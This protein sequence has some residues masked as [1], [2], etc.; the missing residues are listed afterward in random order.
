M[1][2]LLLWVCGKGYGPP[3]AMD[4]W[5]KRGISLNKGHEIM[6]K[7]RNP[8]KAWDERPHRKLWLV[9]KRNTQNGPTLD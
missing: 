9:P 1:E 5:R 4:L 6:A 3:S 8:K 7:M 2:G